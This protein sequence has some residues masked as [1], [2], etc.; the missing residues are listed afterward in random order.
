[1]LD[2]EN[3][4]DKIFSIANSV[5]DERKVNFFVKNFNKF[6]FRDKS[7]ILDVFENFNRIKYNPIGRWNLFLKKHIEV[8]KILLEESQQC[9]QDFLKEDDTNKSKDLLK[10]VETFLNIE[11]YVNNKFDENLMSNILDKI[12]TID[13]KDRT[14][15]ENDNVKKIIS[16]FMK[17]ITRKHTDNEFMHKM[18]NSISYKQLETLLCD[19]IDNMNIS[20]LSDDKLLELIIETQDAI[21][22][23]NISS[24][25]KSKFPEAIELN[26]YDIKNM[27]EE[28]KADYYNK[29][30]IYRMQN[31]ILPKNVCIELLS[32][33]CKDLMTRIANVD[34]ARNFLQENNVKNTVVFFDENLP[35]AGQAIGNS[36]FGSV[37]IQLNTQKLDVTLFH[38]TTH[39]IQN[40]DM[41]LFKKYRGNRYSML[42][43]HLIAFKAM[44]E[45]TY[46]KNYP[47][48]LFEEEAENEGHRLYYQYL[49]DTNSTE[50]T[51]EEIESGITKYSGEVHVKKTVL[52]NGE[53]RN[54]SQ[55]FDELLIK[56]PSIIE[57]YPVLQVEYNSDGTKKTLVQ[58]FDSLESKLLTDKDE[59][60]VL[61]IANC[62]LREI[63][64]ISENEYNGLVSYTSNDTSISN[65]VQ[66]FLSQVSIVKNE[67]LV[68]KLGI[69]SG[70]I[71]TP[72]IDQT[73]EEIEHQDRK[74]KLQ[75]FADF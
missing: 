50:K 70:S 51:R 56:D 46:G 18:K 10:F 28:E 69:E 67:N 6:N 43:D 57:E 25:M 26:N 42:K 74:T 53:E 32:N 54:K 11:C 9:L 35:K 8:A 63:Q 12:C 37:C 36:R 34:Y 5:T 72:Y 48:L 39:A 49:K 38:E 73:Y 27:T 15:I 7:K 14:I 40:N 33:Q 44:D 24:K 22:S 59:D 30:V 68:L 1:M 17:C 47:S 65:I 3:Y 60:E 21:N 58:L 20:T 13:S 61:S 52:I 2:Y 29:L 31:G 45:E 55:L 23:E 41:F 19:Y 75:E 71:E 64:E 4:K 66:Q 16:H 62:I